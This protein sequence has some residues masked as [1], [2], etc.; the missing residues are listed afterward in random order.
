MVA[1]FLV[2]SFESPLYILGINPFKYLYTYNTYLWHR[3]VVS[4]GSL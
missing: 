1:Y 4:N 2:L 3:R